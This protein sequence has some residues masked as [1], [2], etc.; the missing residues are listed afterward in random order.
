MPG[1]PYPVNAEN[2]AYAQHRL[3]CQ[4]VAG[5]YADRL[6]R[7]ALFDALLNRRCFGT[8]W[9]RPAVEFSVC[10]VEMGQEL[11]ADPAVRV[12]REVRATVASSQGGRITLLR[13]NRPIARA[14]LEAPLTEFAFADEEPLDDV[15]ITGAPKRPEP[16]AFYYLKLEQN[17]QLA[18]TSPVWVTG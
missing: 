4:G 3:N 7:G 1:T 9:W 14:R 15:L 10:G 2:Y 8:T 11:P 12:A 5:V 13:N 6:E 17:G 18:W 16:F